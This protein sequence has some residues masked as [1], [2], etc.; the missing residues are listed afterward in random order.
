MVDQKDW[1]LRNQIKYL[2]GVELV[3]TNF[4]TKSKDW[5]HDHCEFCWAKFAKT[6]DAGYSTLDGYYWICFNCFKNF[7][8]MFDWKVVKL[9]DPT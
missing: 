9:K 2:K 1:R 7:K 6:S 4:Q 5:D 8:E 3:Q